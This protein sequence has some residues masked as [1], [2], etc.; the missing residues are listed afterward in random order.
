MSFWDFASLHNWETIATWGF[1]SVFVGVA[2]EGIEIGAKIFFKEWFHKYEFRLEITAGIFWIILVLGLAVENIADNRVWVLSDRQNAWL[3]KDAETAKNNAAQANE[4]AAVAEQKAAE[5]ELKVEEMRAKMADRILTKDDRDFLVSL[6]K[7]KKG[8]N[9][10]I[11]SIM[12]DMEAN[13]YA[14]QFKSVFTDAGWSVDGV[15]QKIDP[16]GMAFGTIICVRDASSP[17]PLA[18]FVLETLRSI[19]LAVGMSN[20]AEVPVNSFWLA[21]GSKAPFSHHP[22]GR[23]DSNYSRP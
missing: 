7:G 14:S 22:N 2:A 1:W 9:I 17:P 8:S 6:I 16:S 12:G 10:V 18:E 3:S 5:D 19:G 4:R 13:R 15:Q 11:A 20:N 23:H 21:V